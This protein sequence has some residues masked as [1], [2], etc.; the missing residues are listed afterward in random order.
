MMALMTGKL[1]PQNRFASTSMSSARRCWEWAGAFIT[2]E[3]RRRI[4]PGEQYSPSRS[5][6]PLRSRSFLLARWR[7]LDPKP[8]PKHFLQFQL[9]RKRAKEAGAILAIDDQDIFVRL[10]LRFHRDFFRF[11]RTLPIE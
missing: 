6:I 10:S 5:C 4:T 7:R 11:Q 3:Q 8:E 9:L 1:R 2:G